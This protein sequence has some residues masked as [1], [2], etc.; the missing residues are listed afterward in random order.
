M[1]YIIGARELN[2]RSRERIYYYITANVDEKKKERKKQAR[3]VALFLDIRI[4]HVVTIFQL[5]KKSERKKYSHKIIYE[6]GARGGVMII[7]RRLGLFSING[8]DTSL[9]RARFY[10]H[11]RSSSLSLERRRRRRREYP[12]V[13][14]KDF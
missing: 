14:V 11:R 4:I 5:E 7:I 10:R 9:A 6:A 13:S 1:R 3:R 8:T 12:S 2:D